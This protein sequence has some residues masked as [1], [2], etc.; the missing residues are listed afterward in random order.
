MF[1]KKGDK[2]DDEFEP[3]AERY[4]KNLIKLFFNEILKHRLVMLI[5]AIGDFVCVNKSVITMVN[6]F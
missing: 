1:Y 6:R 2:K 5:I 3:T 4:K